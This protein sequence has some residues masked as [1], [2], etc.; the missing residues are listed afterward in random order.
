MARENGKVTRRLS[1]REQAYLEDRA[2]W[3][4]NEERWRKNEEWHR[5][6]DARTDRMLRFLAEQSKK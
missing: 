1:L 6:A 3:R 5:K 4:Q 2:R